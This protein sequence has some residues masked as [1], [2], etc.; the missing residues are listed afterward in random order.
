MPIYL[1]LIFRKRGRATM[2]EMET[3][4]G[5]EKLAEKERTGLKNSENE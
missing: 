1:N 5:S 3:D 2:C 4:G